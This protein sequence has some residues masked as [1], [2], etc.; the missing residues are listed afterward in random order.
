MFNHSSSNLHRNQCERTFRLHSLRQLRHRRECILRSPGIPLPVSSHQQRLSLSGRRIWLELNRRIASTSWIT[1]NECRSPRRYR[2]HRY[3]RRRN[4]PEHLQS[5]TLSRNRSRRLSRERSILLEDQCHRN[6]H[7]CAPRAGMEDTPT[8]RS[9]TIPLLSLASMTTLLIITHLLSPRI[10]IR[11]SRTITVERIRMPTHRRRWTIAGL[12][13]LRMHL[14]RLAHHTT[15]HGR[16]TMTILRPGTA[17]DLRPLF[18]TSL[19]ADPLL[20]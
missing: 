13:P 12:T 4:G 20:R 3:R 2:L 10:V 6:D 1:R 9:T 7:L 5:L 19:S 11:T 16:F 17:L 8:D 18:V 14:L 15:L